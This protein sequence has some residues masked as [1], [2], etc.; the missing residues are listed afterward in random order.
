[1]RSPD[2]MPV[3]NYLSNFI[4]RKSLFLLQP[5]HLDLVVFVFEDLQFFLVIEQIHALASVNLE[6]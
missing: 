2:T 1:M 4:G 6:H 3:L 5:E